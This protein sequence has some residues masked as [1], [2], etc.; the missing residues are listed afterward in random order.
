ME[1]GQLNKAIA[2]IQARMQSTRLPSK[3]LMPMPFGE[4]DC[5]LG[6]IVSQLQ[7]SRYINDVF[8]AT[9]T[10]KAD[11]AIEEFCKK[12]SIK[13]FRGDENDVHSRFFKILQNYDTNTVV[14]VTGDNPIIDT[15]ALDNC[16]QKHHETSSDYTYTSGLPTGMNFEIFS[17][18]SF[19]KLSSKNL[20]KEEKEHVTLGYK[21]DKNFNINHIKHNYSP[22]KEIRVTVD[23]ASDYL[24]VSTL[25]QLSKIH[26]IK[27]GLK[28]IDFALVNYPWIFEANQSNFQK[29]Q[30]ATL[31][32]EQLAA[33]ELLKS[34]DFNR[35]INLF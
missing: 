10:N 19:I 9:S 34:L 12:N 26:D 27:P 8:V 28:L 1:V 25:F 2:I 16:I 30:Y 31:E 20:T 24:V 7:S 3:V 18:S 11:D 13:V 23:Y 22:N 15:E 35:I 6:K 14:R 29:K 4:K 33:K 21:N 5:I 17:K 32:E